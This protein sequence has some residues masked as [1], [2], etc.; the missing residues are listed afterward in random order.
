MNV[1]LNVSSSMLCLS[2][3]VDCRDPSG[4]GPYIQLLRLVGQW[5]GLGMGRWELRVLDTAGTIVRGKTGWC[6]L[7]QN[8]VLVDSKGVL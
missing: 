2:S 1:T 3:G 8:G 6:S 7:G 5:R 4:E